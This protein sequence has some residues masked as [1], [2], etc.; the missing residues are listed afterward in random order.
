MDLQM[1]PVLEMLNKIRSFCRFCIGNFEE[2]RTWQR[3]EKEAKI[4]I[5]G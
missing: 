1:L 5:F 4:Y 2:E 3:R